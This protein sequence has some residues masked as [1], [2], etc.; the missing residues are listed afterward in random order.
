M[1]IIQ[2]ISL[3]SVAKYTANTLVCANIRCFMDILRD[4]LEMGHQMTV[5]GLF[6]VNDLTCLSP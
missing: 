6:L 5:G 2:D 1:K 3:P 4:S